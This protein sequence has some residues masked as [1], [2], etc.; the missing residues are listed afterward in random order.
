[1]R[2]PTSAGKG[3]GS[4]SNGVLSWH[5]NIKVGCCIWAIPSYLTGRGEPHPPALGWKRERAAGRRAGTK[6]T[7]NSSVLRAFPA[8]FPAGRRVKRGGVTLMPFGFSIFTLECVCS[9]SLILLLFFL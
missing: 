5:V 9:F 2:R 3:G 6:T 1:M 8:R 4:Y 7:R